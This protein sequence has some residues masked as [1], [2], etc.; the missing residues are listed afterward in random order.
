MPSTTFKDL[1]GQRFGRLV[2]L[3][4]LCKESGRKAK[5]QCCC[6]CGQ[7]ATVYGHHLRAGHTRSCGCLAAETCLVSV[8]TAQLARHQRSRQRTVVPGDTV[9]RW[10][11]LSLAGRDKWGHCR[12]LCQC[13]CGTQREIGQSVLGRTSHSC[14]C[15]RRDTSRRIHWTG[16]GEISGDLFGGIRRS[17]TLRGLAFTVTKEYLWQLFL[18]QKRRCVL[19]GTLLSLSP[20]IAIAGPGTASLDRKNSKRGYVPGNVQWIHRIANVAKQTLTQAEFVELCCLVADRSRSPLRIP[21]VPPSWDLR[22]AV[23]K[24]ADLGNAGQVRN[25]AVPAD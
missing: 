20:S 7:H 19:T 10:T 25:T 22:M 24:R 21:V 15:L 23:P 5:W 14:G 8:R 2:V 9:G 1:T 18:R 6:D 17:A 13:D 4:L 11:V 16:H 3:S 12:W